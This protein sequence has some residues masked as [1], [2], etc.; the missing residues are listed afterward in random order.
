MSKWQIQA[1]FFRD[2]FYGSRRLKPL[3]CCFFN[4]LLSGEHFSRGFR[5]QMVK[6]LTVPCCGVKVQKNTRC[7]R[8]CSEF[9]LMKFV[10][11]FSSLKYHHLRQERQETI[12]KHRMSGRKKPMKQL[13]FST[14]TGHEQLARCTFG[15]ARGWKDT[16]LGACIPSQWAG[17][18]QAQ[19]TR[20]SWHLIWAVVSNI[21]Y[22][23]P[24][25]G[26]IPILANIF[27]RGWNH[28]LVICW[29]A[30]W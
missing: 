11:L 5:S 27:Q 10:G 17:M 9:Q 1:V 22:F 16:H 4:H 23:H 24:Y 12:W 8:P 26:K 15:N 18:G 25:L 21:F 29:Q 3:T 6:C 14:L 13:I 28:Q 7:R 2:R 19:W 20:A 30:Q